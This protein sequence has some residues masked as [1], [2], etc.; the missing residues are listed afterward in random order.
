MADTKISAF[1]AITP[2]DSDA[3]AAVDA[4]T[5]AN[6]KV[7]FS[8]LKSE[9][10]TYL[11]P[12][13][14]MGLT[15]YLRAGRYHV[16]PIGT[17]TVTTS[18]ANNTLYAIPFIMPVGKTISKVAIHV[19]TA[20]GTNCRARLGCYVDNGSTYPNTLVSPN[21]D[22][23]EV[24]LNTTGVKE[25]A[26]FGNWSLSAGVL[27]WLALNA[28][29]SGATPILAGTAGA[30]S[31]LGYEPTAASSSFNAVGGGMWVVSK[32]YGVLPT[33]FTVGAI[34]NGTAQNPFRIAIYW[35]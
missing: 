4:E 32:T 13:Y 7:L 14:S 22:A 26:S 5:A 2:T 28:Q 10:K 27:Y 18:I 16:F 9:L 29:I 24:A 33:T 31:P 6:K 1:D 3:F 15:R 35:A 30:W 25:V 12:L 19:N 23:G 8:A 11:D 21:G 20:G 17:A 34:P